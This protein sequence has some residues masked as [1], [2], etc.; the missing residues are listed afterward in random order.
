MDLHR[1]TLRALNRPKVART[2]VLNI[3]CF[4]PVGILA[5]GEAGV[6]AGSAAIAPRPLTARCSGPWW[7]ACRYAA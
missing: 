3:G 7:R 4:E 1:N 2:E 6:A 5:G